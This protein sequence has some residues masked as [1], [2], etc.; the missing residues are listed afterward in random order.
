MDGEGLFL[1]ENMVFAVLPRACA[2]PL[3]RDL[4][5]DGS[6]K[7]LLSVLET[8]TGRIFRCLCLSAQAVVVIN[9]A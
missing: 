5:A 6:T 3:Y 8:S 7:Q 2:V 9:N 4:A 1:L